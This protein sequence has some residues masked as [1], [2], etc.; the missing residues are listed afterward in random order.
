MLFKLAIKGAR[1]VYER[2]RAQQMT[3]IKKKTKCVEDVNKQETKE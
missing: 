2:R 3:V 1:I